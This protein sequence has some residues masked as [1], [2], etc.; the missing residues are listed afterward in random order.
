MDTETFYRASLN[1]QTLACWLL[2]LI[3]ASTLTFTTYY[4]ITYEQAKR[5]AAEAVEQAKMF[6]QR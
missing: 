6:S 2:V 3:A 5:D 4:I 1:R